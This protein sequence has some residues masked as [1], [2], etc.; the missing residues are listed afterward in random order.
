MASGSWLGFDGRMF[1]TEEEHQ[2]YLRRPPV[3]YASRDIGK[4]PV[5][6][7]VCGEEANDGNPLQASHRVPFT[8]GVVKFKLTP[9]WLDGE[10]NL[11]WAHRKICNKGVEISEEDIPKYLQY[12]YIYT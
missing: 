5:R 8:L 6:C 7:E 9:E 10:H 1:L 11:V 12:N 3:R 4:K 2:T